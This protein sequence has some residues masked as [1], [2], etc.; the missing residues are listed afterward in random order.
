MLFRMVAQEKEF[1]A[2]TF[3][4]VILPIMIVCIL[5]F[6]LY[7]IFRVSSVNTTHFAKIKQ[8]IKNSR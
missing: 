8:L 2:S 6:G 5:L 4:F 7:A 3:W 1:D